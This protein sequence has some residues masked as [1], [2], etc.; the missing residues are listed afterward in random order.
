MKPIFQT[1]NFGHRLDITVT[2]TFY[3]T[4]TKFEKKNYII[5]YNLWQG[6][7][8]RT[9]AAWREDIKVAGLGGTWLE[10]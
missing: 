2:K 9:D 4:S 10:F 1:I 8:C 5:L 3:Y 6:V 7:L